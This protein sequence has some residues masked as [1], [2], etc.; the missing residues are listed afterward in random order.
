M[1]L[2]FGTIGQAL[3]DAINF[4]DTFTSGHPTR[5]AIFNAFHSAIASSRDDHRRIHPPNTGAN[6]T[7]N[8]VIR[9]DLQHNRKRNKERQRRLRKARDLRRLAAKAILAV[10]LPSNAPP[11]PSNAPR[12]MGRPRGTR[13][14]SRKQVIKSRSVASRFRNINTASKNVKKRKRSRKGGSNKRARFLMTFHKSY[15]HPKS[16]KV[17]FVRYH[18]ATWSPNVGAAH[19][20]FRIMANDPNLFCQTNLNVVTDWQ[21]WGTPV[22]PGQ[23]DEFS[24]DYVS[25][26][27][28]NVNYIFSVTPISTPDLSANH[29]EDQVVYQKRWDELETQWT[30]FSQ[31][32]VAPN[33]AFFDPSIKVSLQKT[34]SIYEGASFSLTGNIVPSK[35]CELKTVVDNPELKANTTITVTKSSK[36]IYHEIGLSNFTGSATNTAYLIRVLVQYDV[37]FA[38][39]REV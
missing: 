35:F 11:L 12:N 6:P 9:S 1:P 34:R 14:R 8:A 3:I 38:D 2:N 4:Q 26:Y 28:A 15:I 17:S 22:D 19:H 30:S 31:E 16:K 10:P 37:I 25:Y 24:D 7:P 29:A 20:S 5:N 33:D 23:W 21:E 18:E 13:R 32:A 39:R 36:Q 27:M